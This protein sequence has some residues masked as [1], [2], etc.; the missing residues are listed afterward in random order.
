MEVSEAR[1][2]ART[3]LSDERFC[4]TECVAA[5]AIELAE[6]FGEDIK[7]AEVAALLHDIVKELPKADLLQMIKASDIIGL[8]NLEDCSSVWHAHA[9]AVYARDI[10]GIGA[11]IASAIRYHTTAKADMS[12]LEKIIFLADYTSADRDYENVDEV[13]NILKSREASIEALNE[14]LL[15]ALGMQIE[16]LMG[17]K[18]QIHLDSIRAYNFLT[19]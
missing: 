15:V 4:H 8:D 19:K 9:G 7:K 12:L 3:A 6:R 2:L 5:A 14:A 1:T 13:R 11:D 16:R 10:L 18:R 17:E